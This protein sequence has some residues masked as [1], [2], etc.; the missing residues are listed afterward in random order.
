MPSAPSWLVQ[1]QNLPVSNQWWPHPP[2]SQLRHRKFLLHCP[3]NT[4]LQEHCHTG[5]T[6]SAQSSC[7]T[8]VTPAPPPTWLGLLMHKSFPQKQPCPP[9]S[10]FGAHLT[11][12]CSCGP[13]MGGVGATG[14]AEPPYSN[15]QKMATDSSVAAR[16]PWCPRCV[17][18][19]MEC[20]SC[21]REAAA[22]FSG[23]Q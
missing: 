4:T 11:G 5:T 18:R 22:I 15:P 16:A 9:S 6:F 14:E 23:F 20:L 12:S 8:R 19:R 17:R 2:F 3:L 21:H 10:V 1:H 13:E 7:T